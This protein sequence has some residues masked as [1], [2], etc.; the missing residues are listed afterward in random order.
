MNTCPIILPCPKG[1]KEGGIEIDC[2]YSK[3]LFSV[4]GDTNNTF[5]CMGNP[6]QCYWWRAKHEVG[7]VIFTLPISTDSKEEPK[8]KEESPRGR[9]I[10]LEEE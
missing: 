10:D 1:F 3:G 8:C 7:K 2:P 6:E 9:N 5:I 4:A